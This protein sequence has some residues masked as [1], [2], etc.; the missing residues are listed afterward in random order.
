MEKML[1]YYIVK[2]IERGRERV[3]RDC[4]VKQRVRMRKT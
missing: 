3:R 2:N 1:K 4:I